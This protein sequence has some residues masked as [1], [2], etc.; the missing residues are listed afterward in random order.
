MPTRAAQ[1]RAYERNQPGSAWL[2]QLHFS[3]MKL[4]GAASDLHEAVAKDLDP[5]R[6]KGPIR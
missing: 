3:E 1:V 2:G 4:A 5:G 6:G